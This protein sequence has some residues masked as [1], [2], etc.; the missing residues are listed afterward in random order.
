[1]VTNTGILG[2]ITQIGTHLDPPHLYSAIR[3]CRSWNIA[4]I[5]KLWTSIDDSLYS[6]TL[7]LDSFLECRRMDPS[8]GSGGEWARGV[9]LKYGHLVQDLRIQRRE[10]LDA[11]CCTQ[12][13]T[14]LKTLKFGKMEPVGLQEL[15]HEWMYDLSP[16]EQTEMAEIRW[17]DAM[18]GIVD[19]VTFQQA[20]EPRSL[21][22]SKTTLAQ[23]E[24]DWEVTRGFWMLLKKNK[25]LQVLRLD[26]SLALFMDLVSDE[27]FIET[28]RSLWELRDLENDFV[29]VELAAVMQALPDL[30]RYAKFTDPCGP[31]SLTEPVRRLTHVEVNRSISC[32]ELS[33][34]LKNAPNLESLSIQSLNHAAPMPSYQESE[35]LMDDIYSNL[36]RLQIGT[37]MGYYGYLLDKRLLDTVLPW[38]SDLKTIHLTR[39]HVNLVRSFSKHCSVLTTVEG[40]NVGPILQ[41]TP[42]Q[43]QENHEARSLEEM[44]MT[45]PSLEKIDWIGRALCDTILWDYTGVWPN[46]TFL[47][48]QIGGLKVLPIE[49]EAIRKQIKGLPGPFRFKE[50][51]VFLQQESIRQQQRLVLSRIGSLRNLKTLD[52]GADFQLHEN[53]TWAEGGQGGSWV[54]K[55]R[56][57]MYDCLR[58]SLEMGLDELAGLKN[59]EVFGFEGIEHEIGDAELGWMSENWGNLKVMRGLC[60]TEGSLLVETEEDMRKARLLG[61]MKRLRPDVAHEPSG[62]CVMVPLV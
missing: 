52:I 18:E 12:A 53:T 23:M 1:M 16:E 55:K 43:R 11:V 27:Y 45:C 40:S 24:V 10:V 46:L 47:R 30:R 31:L 51:R 48:C 36:Q 22:L 60:G 20:F 7:I 62:V 2:I 9:F 42:G 49:F 19:S 34:F 61:V 56:P 58:L 26:E 6:W 57:R 21:D 4:L 14:M 44:I 39:L 54:D 13:C 29:Q 35:L 50:N 33:Q 28:L 3:V 17:Q 38:M 32:Q 15:E 5:P 25:G 37:F 59:L 41:L 8:D